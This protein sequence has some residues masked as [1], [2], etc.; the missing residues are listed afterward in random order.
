ME[1]PG[2][3][4]RLVSTIYFTNKNVPFKYNWIAVE[5]TIGVCNLAA[6]GTSETTS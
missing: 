1:K 4:F 3:C 2:R 5:L 6:S